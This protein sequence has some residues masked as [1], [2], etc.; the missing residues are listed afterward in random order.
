MQHKVA[1]VLWICVL[2]GPVWSQEPT[3]LHAPMPQAIPDANYQVVSPAVQQATAASS[4]SLPATR[5][6]VSA[7]LE[8]SEFMLTQAESWV[9]P[10]Q[11]SSSVQVFPHDGSLGFDPCHVVDDDVLRPSGGCAGAMLRQA[12]GAQ[13]LVACTSHN[14]NC[15]VHHTTW[16]CGQR[17]SRYTTM[18][19]TRM[20]VRKSRWTCRLPG[21]AGVRP[22]R[23]PS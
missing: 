10:N 16:S 1:A 17:G 8:M 11:M 7:E 19:S 9:S 22:I 14:R 12:F 18:R 2:A 5:Q 3:D 21:A 4:E 13:Q 20:S 23:V 6:A 15:H